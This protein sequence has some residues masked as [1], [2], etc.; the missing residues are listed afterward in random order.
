MPK[1]RCRRVD[2]EPMAMRGIT[3][4][5]RGY[6]TPASEEGITGSICSAARE[7]LGKEKVRYAEADIAVLPII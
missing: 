6:V 4:I 7:K 2:T 3:Q 5:R 1:A